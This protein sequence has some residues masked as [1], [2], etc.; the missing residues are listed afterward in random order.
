MKKNVLITGASGNLG[1]ATVDKFLKEGYNVLATVTP[2]KTLGFPAPEVQLYEADLTDE[3]SVNVVVKQIIAD[4][5]V[6]HAALLLV[7][8]FAPGTI[9]NT[10][11]SLLKKM[12]SL[13]F[14]TAYFVARPVFQQMLTQPGGGRIVLVGARP[15]LQ[16]KEGKNT[17][18]YAL[19]KSLIFKLADFLNAEGSS[20]NVTT[21]VIVP[22]T[23]D[24]ET[25]R[26]A[27][28]DKDFTAWV[29]PEEI[30]EII[31]F[32]SSDHGKPLRET[33]LKIYNRA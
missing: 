21:T 28:P 31:A 10:D 15:A 8:G 30:A 1:K 32:L 33:V 7:G 25:N 6:L 11:G 3:N 23:I 13:N 17:L 2:G 9:Q 20:K 12:L 16:P 22:S 26:N 14:D 19:S 29:K 18:A 24:T 27:M 4:H 5:S